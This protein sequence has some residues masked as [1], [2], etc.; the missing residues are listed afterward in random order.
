[1]RLRAFAS[2]IITDILRPRR[3]RERAGLA[4]DAS[5]T[6]A[7]GR[8]LYTTYAY[9]F[10]LAALVLLVAIIAAIGLTLRRRKDTKYQDPGRQVRVERSARGRLG[11][12]PAEKKS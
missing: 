1:M 11:K 12:M 3:G 9:P 7:L 2:K 6:R 8:L 5:N 4:A 10:E